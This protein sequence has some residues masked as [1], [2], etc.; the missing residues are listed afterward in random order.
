MGRI[1]LNEKITEKSKIVYTGFFKWRKKRIMECG[2]VVYPNLNYL[3]GFLQK[4]IFIPTC[5]ITWFYKEVDDFLFFV[6]IF[7]ESYERVKR[8]CRKWWI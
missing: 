7:E 2:W 4:N 1:F 3:L 8:R 5:L 6:E